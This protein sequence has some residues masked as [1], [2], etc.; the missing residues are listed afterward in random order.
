MV[1]GMSGD[2]AGLT[3]P[4]ELESEMTPAVRAFVEVLLKRIEV[5][6]TENRALQ[7]RVE[8][9]EARLPKPKSKRKRG[10]QP[11]KTRAG[12]GAARRRPGND[13][14]GAGDCEAAGLR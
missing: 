6:E 12:T 3:I 14:A 7:S 9:L 4:S 10:G 8:K 5:L 1:P 13:S 2:Q 11:S